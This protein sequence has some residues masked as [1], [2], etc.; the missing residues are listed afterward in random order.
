MTFSHNIEI[1]QSRTTNY[2][3]NIFEHE[4]KRSELFVTI[5]VLFKRGLVMWISM[6]S[7]CLPWSPCFP[8]HKR[9][10]RSIMTEFTV[11]LNS[12]LII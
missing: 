10:S 7:G 4:R 12:V 9:Q 6:Y 3:M 5:T 11:V 1:L 8:G 2:S